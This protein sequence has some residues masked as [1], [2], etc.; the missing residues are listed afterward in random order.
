MTVFKTSLM[1]S[2]FV[3]DIILPIFNMIESRNLQDLA[4]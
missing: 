2:E 1:V 4:N 3:P